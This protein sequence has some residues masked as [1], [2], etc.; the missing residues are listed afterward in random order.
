MKENKSKLEM[1]VHKR[2]KTLKKKKSQQIIY[3]YFVDSHN[4]SIFDI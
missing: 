2:G 3:F 4:T 1:F